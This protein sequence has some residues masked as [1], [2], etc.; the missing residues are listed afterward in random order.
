MQ[1]LISGPLPN[2]EA[3][4]VTRLHIDIEDSE[5]RVMVTL[6]GYTHIHIYNQSENFDMRLCRVRT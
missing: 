4:D 5:V 3:T 6:H 1:S 2:P